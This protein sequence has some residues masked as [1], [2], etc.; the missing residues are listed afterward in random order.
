MVYII[1]IHN[2]DY[3]KRIVLVNKISTYL[4]NQ[5]TLNGLQFKQKSERFDFLHKATNYQYCVSFQK[6]FKMFLLNKLMASQIKIDITR[7]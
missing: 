5:N 1:R 7:I 3:K 2:E 6:E 4:N